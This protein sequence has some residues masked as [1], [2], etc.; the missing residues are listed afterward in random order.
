MPLVHF[1]LIYDHRNQQLV[2]QQEF[3]DASEAAAEY[4][5]MEAEHRNEPNL[6]IVLVGADSIETIKRTHGK[7]FDGAAV[8]GASPFLV[9]SRG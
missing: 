6:E 2:H 1:L 7:Y 4:G 9:A 3:S 5:R 8:K